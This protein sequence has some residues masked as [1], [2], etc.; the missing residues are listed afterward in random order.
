MKPLF[1][2]PVSKY[3]LRPCLRMYKYQFFVA[4]ISKNNEELHSSVKYFH[5][6]IK[7]KNI[8]TSTH[9][10][11]QWVTV[12]KDLWCLRSMFV[13]TPDDRNKLRLGHELGPLMTGTA[14]GLIRHHIL[15][16]T[17]CLCMTWFISIQSFL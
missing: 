14:N 13:V 4:F 15:A 16:R 2:H 7:S 10:F 8:Q 3:W 9:K 6:L 12:N 5:K 17:S 1:G 11:H